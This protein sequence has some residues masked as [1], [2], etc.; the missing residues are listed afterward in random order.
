[1]KKGVAG[2]TLIELM[3]VVV[4]I[5]ILAG[6]VYPS[7][8]NYAQKSR[9]SDAQILLLQA[10]AK[11]EKFFSDCATYAAA[12]DGT[13]MSCTAPGKLGLGSATPFSNQGDYQLA[14]PEAG[15]ITGPGCQRG[16]AGASLS[17][18]FTLTANPVAGKSQAN[19]G[20]LRID[21]IG[22][23]QWNRNNSGT[24]VSWNAN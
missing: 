12:L 23:R 16:T 5:G 6:I 11:Q 3:V 14:V 15:N 13:A 18:G 10:A 2:V 7:Y 22:N 9:R 4:V 1:M 21:A 17:C 19:N 24:W 20:A 8:R